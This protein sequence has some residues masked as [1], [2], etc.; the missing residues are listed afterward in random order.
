MANDATPL[1]HRSGQE[2]WY[3][4]EGQN[5]N[6]EDITCADESGCLDRGVDVEA[7][8]Q[9]LWLIADYSHGLAVQSGESNDDVLSVCAEQFEEAAFVDDFSNH[10]AHIVWSIRVG[11]EDFCQ[12]VAGSVRWVFASDADRLC[13]GV[14]WQVSENLDG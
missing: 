7:A 11:G 1:L 8:R 9:N 5:W 3:V 14:V 13:E 10:M 4:D 2:T 12:F 6:V